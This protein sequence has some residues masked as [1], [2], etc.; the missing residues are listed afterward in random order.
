MDPLTLAIG[1]AFIFAGRMLDKDPTNEELA[2]RGVGSESGVPTF[3]SHVPGDAAGEHS[4]LYERSHGIPY[5]R[6][7]K[8][9]TYG[10]SQLIYTGADGNIHGHINGIRPLPSDRTDRLVDNPLPTPFL[11]I[12]GQ[13][14]GTLLRDY[15]MHGPKFNNNLKEHTGSHFA[16]GDVFVSPPNPQ[17]AHIDSRTQAVIPT[18]KSHTHVESGPD[19]TT[20]GAMNR[21]DLHQGRPFNSDFDIQTHKLPEKAVGVI[22]NRIGPPQSENAGNTNLINPEQFLLDPMIYMKVPDKDV[23]YRQPNPETH[24]G[25]HGRVTDNTHFSHTTK[26]VIEGRGGNAVNPAMLIAGQGRTQHADIVHKDRKIQA[27]I[28]ARMHGADRNFANYASDWKMDHN[29]P[30]K[31]SA[32]VESR[33]GHPHAKQLGVTG[34][35]MQNTIQD[36]SGNE[37][38]R[39]AKGSLN[40]IEFDYDNTDYLSTLHSNPFYT[41]VTQP[42]GRVY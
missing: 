16:A 26:S 28:Q 33:S 9:G 38:T 41:P 5:L 31:M 40:E 27:G 35:L 12:S 29:A 3:S 24:P 32:C 7:G 30:S 1:G 6:A 17:Q 11:G 18:L 23:A 22:D 10:N 15:Y 14:D 34:Y 19:V 36:F 13:E 21:P 20:M 42:L 37:R 25:Q 8:D 39:N 4:D 2:A